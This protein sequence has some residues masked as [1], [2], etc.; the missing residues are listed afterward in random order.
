M[1]PNTHDIILCDLTKNSSNDGEVMRNLL[2]QWDKPFQK[3]YGDGIYDSEECYKAIENLGA[4]PI[5]PVRS[6]ARYRENASPYMQTRNQQILDIIALGGD[7]L[8]RSL[9]K[10]LK[11]YHRRSL[12]E[13]TFSRFKTILGSG[14]KSRK[15]SSQRTEAIMKCQILN[16]MNQLGMPIS[17][18]A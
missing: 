6:T 9:W 1:D 7:E 4:E 15:K 13:T 11:G 3:V 8:A 18:V 12:V 5:I 14:L 10:K 2:K 17:Y 16:K